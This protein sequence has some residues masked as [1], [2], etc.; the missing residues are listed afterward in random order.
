MDEHVSDVVW[1]FCYVGLRH[2]EAASQQSGVGVTIEWLPFLLNPNMAE[3]GEDLMQHLTKKYGPSVVKGFK[4]SNSAIAK[5]G[6]AV[7]INWNNNRKIFNT[8]KAHAL[9]QHMKSKDNDMANKF[10]EDIFIKYFE[11]GWDLSDTELLI[12]L[13]KHAGL[14]E[15]DARVGIANDKQV[16]ILQEDREIK[17]QWRVSGVPFFIIGESKDDDPI[18]FAGAYPVD[19]IAKQLKAASRR[20]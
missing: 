8:K 2:L 14:D 1:P 11:E 17:S 19:F 13:A 10:M 5:M 9:I 6:R 15:M 16:E 3:E 4:D 7:G 18:V 12:S 20:K